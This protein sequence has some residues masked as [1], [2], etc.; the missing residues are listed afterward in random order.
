MIRF[1]F[2]RLRAKTAEQLETALDYF[3]KQ[4]ARSHNITLQGFDFQSNFDDLIV[5]LGQHRQV[6][7]LIDEYDKP[8]IDN[9]T[10]L[11][12]AKRIRDA[13]KGFYTIIKSQDQ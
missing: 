8:I 13:L 4:I 7:I 6:V 3:L 12:Q 2:S 5:Q 9:L 1:D 10:N 11:D